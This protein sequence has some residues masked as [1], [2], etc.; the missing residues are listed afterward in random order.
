MSIKATLPFDRGAFK[1]HAELCTP[2]SGI[3]ALI[4]PSGSGKT[5]ILRAIAG[6]DRV[7][8]ATVSV[9]DAVWQSDKKFVPTHL[10]R[11][12][13]V[14]Q[15]ASL[16]DHLTCQQ[17]IDYAKR[18]NRAPDRAVPEN[19]DPLD[20][21]SFAHRHPSTLSGGERQRV[22][23]ARALASRIDLL[24]MDEPLAGLDRE[25]KDLILP[26]LESLSQSV[27]I[28]ILYVTHALDEV[29]RFSNYAALIG[30]EAITAYGATPEILTRLD[31]PLSHLSDAV[32][33]IDATVTAYDTDYDITRLAFQGGELA[34]PGVSL[35]LHTHVRVRI[36]AKDVS[37]TLEPQTHTSIL[38]VLP[39]KI[40]AIADDSTSQATVLLQVG[41][42]RLLARLTRKSV[43][44]LELQPGSKVHAQVKSVAIV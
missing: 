29:A 23:I 19:V 18:F 26:Y 42:A 21:S 28:P 25:Q 44:K 3:T 14:F 8:G 31:L 38:N 1:L 32:S 27:G 10:R 40:V 24:L 33:I 7:S 2:A 37:L 41:D 13:Y 16:F 35:P 9:N 4:G 6:L 43:Q 36:A 5:S 12:G 17:N 15:E 20:V 11:V 39:A 30:P 22:A 34:A